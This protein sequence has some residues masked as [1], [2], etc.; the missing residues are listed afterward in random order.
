[1]K[2]LLGCGQVETVS[3]TEQY[4]APSR[5]TVV[6]ESVHHGGYG[7][8]YWMRQSDRGK[9][10]YYSSKYYKMICDDEGFGIY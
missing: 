3:I 7:V 9:L 1:M 2:G 8:C 6:S 4:C 10:K 5:S